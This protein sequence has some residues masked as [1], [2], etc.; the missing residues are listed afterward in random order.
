MPAKFIPYTGPTA[1][2]YSYQ[3]AVR[4][5]LDA[6]KRMD[7]WRSLQDDFTTRAEIV[8]QAVDEFLARQK[9][10]IPHEGKVS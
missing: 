5:T 6:V 3:V 4:F 9:V 2:E 10:Q 1:P 8:R 7:H